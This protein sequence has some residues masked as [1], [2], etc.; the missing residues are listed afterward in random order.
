MTFVILGASAGVGRCLAKQ[1]A[2]A[3]HHLV[4]VASDERDLSAVA[5]DLDVRYKARTRILAVD[6][7]GSLS[8]LDGIA[9]AARD[10]G[11]LD[12][13]LAPV[14]AV[15]PDDD[16]TFD[17]R[18]V[19]RLTTVN[20][21]AVVATITRFLPD[22]MHRPRA[23]IVGFGSVAAVRGR[24]RNVAY[25]AAKRA[26]RSFFESLRHACAATPVVAQFY[27]LGYIDTAQTVALQTA[28]PLGDPQRLS[29]L[30][31]RNVGR[32]VGE[33]YYP[34]FWRPLSALVRCTPWFLFRQVR[35]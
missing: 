30:V 23:T 12:G 11:P 28:I 5:S 16:C 32:D 18:R 17:E 33:V 26:L 9:A 27:V 3:G 21:Q 1:F 20:Y 24:S 25:A 8:Y 10:L 31:L 2:E 7:G 4:L 29:A 6:L 14:G 22:L 19:T 13:V 34:G 15:A 35:F